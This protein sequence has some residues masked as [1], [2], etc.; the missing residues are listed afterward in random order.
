ML[1]IKI[2]IKV[3]KIYLDVFDKYAGSMYRRESITTMPNK[4]ENGNRKTR[5]D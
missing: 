2:I 4:D 5:G 1:K 3:K